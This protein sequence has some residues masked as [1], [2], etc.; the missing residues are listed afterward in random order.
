MN[1]FVTYQHDETILYRSF[2]SVIQYCLGG[3]DYDAPTCQYCSFCCLVW[4]PIVWMQ[5]FHYI[6]IFLG[7]VPLH[8]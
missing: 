5:Q 4:M 1:Y 7:L 6:S 8:V 3:I 2:V